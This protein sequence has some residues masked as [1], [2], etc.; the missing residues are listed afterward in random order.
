MRASYAL[1]RGQRVA[2]RAGVQSPQRNKLI[3]AGLT[4]TLVVAVLVV[5]VWLPTSSST[6]AMGRERTAAARQH[7]DHTTAERAAA[8]PGSMWRS[9]SEQK[10][11]K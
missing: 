10:A 1:L 6:A 7:A 4:S 3:V 11:A 9:M 5:N 2:S 8:V